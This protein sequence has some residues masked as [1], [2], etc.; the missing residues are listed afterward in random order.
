MHFNGLKTA[1]L[2]GVMSAIIV[3]IGALFQSPLILWGSV[4]VAVG[5]NAYVYFNSAKMSLKAM[6]AQPVT[7]LQAPVIYRIVRE[8]ATAAHQPMPAL[9]ISPTESPNAFATGRNPKNA[10]VCCTTGILQLLDERELRAVLGH[11][12][13]H[14]YNRDI[15]ISSIAGAMAAVISGLANFAMFMGAFG[16]RDNG[17]N[18]LAMILIAFLGPISAT[19]VKMAVSRSR[20]FQADESGAEL[21]GDP[22]AL[23]SALAKISGGVQAAPL[24]PQPD[25]AAQSHMMIE[26]PFR[27]GDRMAKMFSTHPPTAE[28]IR[29]LQEMARNGR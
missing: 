10:A 18:P 22:L 27:A 26:S 4:I 11:E 1:A 23:A 3:G 29:R 16:G 13:S 2:L 6:H 5:M 8:L 7:E 24:P 21:T 14:V 15:L 12:L 17:P 25:I 19:L 28:R 20:E 9:Y